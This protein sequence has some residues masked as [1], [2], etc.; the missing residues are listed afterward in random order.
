VPVKSALN[1]CFGIKEIVKRAPSAVNTITLANRCRSHVAASAVFKKKNEHKFMPGMSPNQPSRR[2][3][4]TFVDAL[5]NWNVR[6][7]LKLFLSLIE[8]SSALGFWISLIGFL[9]MLH[10][11]HRPRRL[12]L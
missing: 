2:L 12:E 7:M 10:M 6:T 4:S 11:E 3:S 1:Y 9:G 8:G 5:T